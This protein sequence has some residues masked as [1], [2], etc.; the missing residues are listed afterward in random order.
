MVFGNIEDIEKRL[1]SLQNIIDAIGTLDESQIEEQG[2]KVQEIF[3]YMDAF[4]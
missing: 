3:D 4:D 1:E 2:A